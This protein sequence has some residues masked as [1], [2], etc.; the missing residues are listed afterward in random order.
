MAQDKGE[1]D[2]TDKP[3]TDPYYKTE[4]AKP[5][6]EIN[7]IFI[8][9][10]RVSAMKL[11]TVKDCIDR[12]THYIAFIVDGVEVQVEYATAKLAKMTFACLARR[13]KA[14]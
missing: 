7:D 1:V 5:F 3:V 12:S 6:Y 9:L 2:M 13:R 4:F 8:D 11:T 14:L 10:R